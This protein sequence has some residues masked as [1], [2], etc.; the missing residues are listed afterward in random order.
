SWPV[1]WG[2]TAKDS[3]SNWPVLVLSE[4]DDKS[5]YGVVMR[6][7]NLESNALRFASLYCDPEEVGLILDLLMLMQP[8]DAFLGW[9]K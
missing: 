1:K 7:P 3:L 8:D 9:F 2:L 4:R 6:S 5:V